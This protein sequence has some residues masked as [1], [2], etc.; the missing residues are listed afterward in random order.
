MAEATQD[1][2]SASHPQTLLTPE[3]A[4]SARLALAR[5]A[6]L[7]GGIAAPEVVRE[8]ILASWTR[9]QLWHVPVDHLDVPFESDL[10]G[11]SALLR[12]AR[13]VLREAAEQFGNEPVS[14]I[15]C[16]ANG[17]VLTRDT[18]DAR[19]EANL[20][21]V[22]LAPGFSYAEE[23]VGTNGIGTALEGGGPARVFGHEHYV[24]HLEE[25]ACTGVP[26]RHPVTH[27][28]LGVVDLT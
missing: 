5:T 10:D 9:S 6:F 7:T 8:P 11:E 2:H 3:D 17:I 18:G 28:V 4:G 15:L 26:V 27:K 21:R 16:D 13:P 20:D 12:A 23:H 14:V 22:W 24:E 25:F 19:L 1:R